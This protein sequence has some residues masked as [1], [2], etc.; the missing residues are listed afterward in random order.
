MEVEKEDEE[1]EKKITDEGQQQLT[2]AASK[3]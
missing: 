1:K 2:R 3:W